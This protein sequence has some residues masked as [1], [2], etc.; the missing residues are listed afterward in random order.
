MQQTAEQAQVEREG[1]RKVLLELNPEAINKD[2]EDNWAVIA[3]AVQ[4]V[5]R[6][7]GHPNPYEAL[8]KLTRK[9]EKITKESFVKFI[10][11]LNVSD[12]LKKRLK[13]ITPF[14]Y[15]GI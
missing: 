7:E 13:K 1:G 12:A 5:L 4:T 10:D 2:L 3:E 9:N 11:G 15:T 14:N 6:K 8:K